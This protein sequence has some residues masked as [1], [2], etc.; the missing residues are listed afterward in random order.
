MP[1]D[2]FLE[3]LLGSLPPL[4]D[5][6]ED[7]PAWRAEAN[8]EAETSIGQLL[9]PGPEVG[10]VDVVQ[11]PV[12]GGASIDLRIYQPEGLGPH[13]IHL[14]L[15]G[16]GWI[17]GTVHSTMSDITCRERCAGAGCVVVAVEYRKAPEHPFPTPLDDC[18]AALHWVVQNAD[19]LNGRADAISIGGQSAGANLAAALTLRLRD[20]KGPQP[21]FVLLE[22]P[23]LDATL[24]QPAYQQIGTGYG[25]ET[26]DIARMLAW[27]T[28]DLDQRRGPYVSPLLADD[29]T[30]LPETYVMAAEY[31]PVRDDGALYVQRLVEAG[32]TATFSLQKGHVHF[33]GALTRVMA[34]ARA[35][36]DEAVQALRDRAVPAPTGSWAH[37]DRVLVRDE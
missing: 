29:L 10:R 1:V 31:D 19:S 15:H 37:D 5:P 36:R 21:V 33:S 8:R 30:G 22:V 17:G 28:P 26:A 13:P 27:Y 18:H 12:G 24:S 4:P 16:G 6:I 7:F 11:I 14:F 32:V 3:P 9:E 2:P 35:W 23:L 34:S 20:E 25:L